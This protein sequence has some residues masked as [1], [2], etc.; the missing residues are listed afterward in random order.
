MRRTD[1]DVFDGIGRWTNRRMRNGVIPS[2]TQEE[3][4]EHLNGSKVAIDLCQSVIEEA[5]QVALAAIVVNGEFI[6]WPS[7]EEQIEPTDALVVRAW[8]Q[9][10][11]GEY[12]VDCLIV[13]SA[14]S[15]THSVVLEFDGHDFHEK[16][17]EQAQKDKSRDR[18]L[19]AAGYSVLRFTGA[20]IWARPEQCAEEIEEYLQK[21]AKR[22]CV[23]S[24]LEDEAP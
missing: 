12:R 3:Y 7:S 21:Q 14:R 19:T 11:I 4:A 22:L 9:K 5:M 24:A 15:S 10:N 8:W 20:E 23:T 17:K 6:K 13:I 1:A 2:M 18:W 16:T